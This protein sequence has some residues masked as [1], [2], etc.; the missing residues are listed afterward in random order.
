M[1]CCLL[2]TEIQKM[3]SWMDSTYQ[4]HLRRRCHHHHDRHHRRKN[5]E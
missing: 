3:T 2:P 1:A 5:A 4:N